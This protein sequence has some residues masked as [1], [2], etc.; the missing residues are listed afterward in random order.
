MLTT[1]DDKSEHMKDERER[2]LFFGGT[3]QRYSGKYYRHFEHGEYSC[4]NCG[5]VLAS[6]TDKIDTDIGWASFKPVESVEIA[7]NTA[8]GYVELFLNCVFCKAHIGHVYKDSDSPHNSVYAF[9]SV[10]LEF[11]PRA[12]CCGKNK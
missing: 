1:T 2:V 10:A 7:K 4:A 3:E 8:R 9:N 5:A 11:D 6:H 12:K